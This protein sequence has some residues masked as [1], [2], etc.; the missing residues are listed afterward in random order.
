MEKETDGQTNVQTDGGDCITSHANAVGNK[1]KL[2]PVV[3][4]IIVCKNV[5]TET[6]LKLGSRREVTYVD[7]SGSV[8]RSEIVQNRRLI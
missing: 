7:V 8:S 2:K 4:I 3:F 6:K 5:M 1:E